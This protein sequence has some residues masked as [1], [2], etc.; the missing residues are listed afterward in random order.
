MPRNDTCVPHEDARLVFHSRYTWAQKASMPPE[1]E[2]M[3]SREEAE[4]AERLGAQYDSSG[5]PK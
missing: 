1:L 2:A 5:P 4:E 3:I